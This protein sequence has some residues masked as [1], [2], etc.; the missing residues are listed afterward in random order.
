MRFCGA[1]AAAEDKSDAR[2]DGVGRRLESLLSMGY[3][4]RLDGGRLPPIYDL[5][6]G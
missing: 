4:A 2:L 3:V 6:G 1:S 5:G